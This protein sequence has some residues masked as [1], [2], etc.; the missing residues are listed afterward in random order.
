[1]RLSNHRTADHCGIYPKVRRMMAFGVP[2]LTTPS[3]V[4]ICTQVVYRI[5]SREH[6]RRAARR[7]PCGLLLSRRLQRRRARR[8]RG[9]RNG[10]LWVLV[11]TQT[12]RARVKRED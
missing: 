10:P 6:H 4:F 3:C 7:T 12:T 11:P 1:M 5:V 2:R 9:W 8:G